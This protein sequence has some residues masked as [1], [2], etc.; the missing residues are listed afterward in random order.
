MSPAVNRRASRAAFGAFA[1]SIA[2]VANAGHHDG[3]SVVPLPQYA[4]ECGSCHV[5]YSPWLLP[6]A[7]W[8]EVM[9]GLSRH[10]GTDASLD[11][12]TAKAI[13]AWLEANAGT[14]KRAAAAAPQ[15][16]ITRSAWFVHEHGEIAPAT[17]R[18]ASIRSPSN[19]AACHAAA[20][21]GDF[22]EHGAR[23]PR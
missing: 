8:R 5:P 13:G 19:C 12:A 15:N 4:Q 6:A 9:A 10:F 22:H 21:R 7:S 1:A 11:E 23:I 16:R 17:W 3:R 14:G 20:E 18:R 2:L